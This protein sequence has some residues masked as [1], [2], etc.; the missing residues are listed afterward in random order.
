MTNDSILIVLHDGQMNGVKVEEAPYAAVKD[1]VLSNGETLPTLREYLEAA[2]RTKNIRL[3][4][5]LKISSSAATPEWICEAVRRVVQLVREKKLQLRTDYITFHLEAA[6]E[7]IRLAPEADV[8]YLSGDKSP[9]E[10]KAAGFAGLDYQ[11]EVMRKN[12][13][14]FREAKAKGLGI[15]VWTV[16]DTTVVREMIDS[17]ADF[18][19]TDIPADALKFISTRYDRE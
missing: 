2:K 7:F 8:Y 4:L 9:A 10:L 15:N 13:H 19:T 5:E 16:N 1:F 17:G 12:P 6:K 3:V 11:I 14:W 18:I